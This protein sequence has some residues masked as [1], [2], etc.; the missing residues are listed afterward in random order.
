MHTMGFTS[1]T[2]A[3]GIWAVFGLAVTQ[4]SA[5]GD[6]AIRFNR[7][8]RP[9]LSDN[10]FFCHGPD[11]GTREADLRLDTAEGLFGEQPGEGPVVAGDVEASELVRRIRSED[12]G[13][14]MPP[15]GAHKELSAE[16]RDLLEA[17]VREGA[18]FEGHWAFEPVA[19]PSDDQTSSTA[20]IDAAIDRRV[21]EQGLPI[22][23]RTDRVTLLRRLHFDLIGLPPTPDEAEAFLSDMSADAYERLVDRLLASPHYGERMAMWWLDLVRYADTVGYH[24]DQQMSVSPFR[25]YAIAAFNGNMPFDQFTIEQIA[26]DLL[27]E[28][29]R[30]QQIAAGYNRLGMMSAEGGVQPKEYLAKYIAERVRNVSGAWL[31]ITLGCAEC[32]DHK[33]DPFTTRD[34]YRFEAFFADIKERGLYAGGDWGPKMRLPTAEQEGR[35]AELDAAIAAL[36]EQDEPPQEDVD[37]LVKQREAVEAAVLTTLV[38]ETVE[39]RMV[40]VLARGNWMDESG[41]EVTPGFPESLAGEP[42][43]DARLTR[44]DLARWIVDRRNP[45]TARVLVNRLWALLFGE[46]LSRRLD[47]VGAQGEWPSHPGLL[48]RLAADFMAQGWDVKR[49]VKAIVMSEAYQRSSVAAPEVLAA[50]PGNRWLARQGRFRLDAELVRDNA[51][52]V[53]GL[54]VRR[55]GGESVFPYQPVGYWAYLNFPTRQWQQDQGDDPY[56]RGLYTHW[57]RQYLHPSLLAFDAPSRE[58]CTAKRARSNTPLQSLALLNDPS[59]VEAARVFAQEILAR[60]GGSERER[61]DFAFQRAVTRPATDEEAAVLESLLADQ[62]EAYAADPEAATALLA[63]GEAAVPEALDA[64]ELAAWTNV[65][66]AI[67]NLHEVVTRN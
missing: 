55:I 50:D 59:Y 1:A 48:D 44:L 66:R 51:L 41:D 39:P 27:P 26:G 23:P 15:P 13:E 58:E 30:E 9:I 33:F 38:T 47:D 3:A 37:A 65:A 54:L 6:E 20:A 42:H 49:L 35:L 16:Q 31:G 19:L 14:V 22:A 32:H 52:A 46:G 34:F 11:A 4:V 5:L 25:D 18:D 24:G 45:L 56:R 28:P 7:D 12:A 63:V 64:A 61:I 21:G 17:W 8:I 40:R 10:C 60:G 57:Q 43:T 36:K 67:L 29:T 2:I 53:S 62:R